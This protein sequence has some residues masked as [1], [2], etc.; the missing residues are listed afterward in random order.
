MISILDSTKKTLL[1]VAGEQNTQKVFR[2]MQDMNFAG[3]N[4]Q[5]RRKRIRMTIILGSVKLLLKST[6]FN[7]KE[8]SG[9]I[10]PG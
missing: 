8:E 2:R 9:S 1:G 10:N 6:R 7:M 4:R 3:P 5:K